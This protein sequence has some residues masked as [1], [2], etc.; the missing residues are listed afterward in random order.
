MAWQGAFEAEAGL[1]AFLQVTPRYGALR[2]LNIVLQDSDKSEPLSR[3]V[4]QPI[5]EG[6]TWWLEVLT[7]VLPHTWMEELNVAPG[8]ASNLDF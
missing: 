8:I 5:P 6:N 7:E 2:S 4:L 1:V 3:N